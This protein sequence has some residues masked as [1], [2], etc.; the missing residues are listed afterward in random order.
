MD[1]QETEADKNCRVRTQRFTT[2]PWP[3]DLAMAGLELMPF[4]ALEVWN[5]RYWETVWNGAVEFSGVAP[6]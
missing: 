4:S 3:F 6:E 1:E 2:D 5:G